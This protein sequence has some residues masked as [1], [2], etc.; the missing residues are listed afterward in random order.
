MFVFAATADVIY[1][2]HD[3]RVI[4]TMPFLV[5]ACVLYPPVVFKPAKQKRLCSS[6]FVQAPAVP[7]AIAMYGLA[8]VGIKIHSNTYRK[9]SG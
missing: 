3:H 6:F 5:I 2:A 7:N 4:V 8:C 1:Q 9:K